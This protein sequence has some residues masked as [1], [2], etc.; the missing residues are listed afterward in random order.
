MKER[1]SGNLLRMAGW[2]SLTPLL[3]EFK[4]R[5]CAAFPSFAPSNDKLCSLYLLLKPFWALKTA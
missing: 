3:R 1:E 5:V 2:S 4:E